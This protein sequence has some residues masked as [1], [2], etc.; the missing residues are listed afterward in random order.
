MN[1]S[2]ARPSNET[3]TGAN[4]YTV[5]PGHTLRAGG[6]L[7]REGEKAPLSDADARRLLESGAI[8]AAD[9]GTDA[10]PLEAAVNG[11]ASDLVASL[12]TMDDAQLD[13]IEQLERE[14]GDKA[15][16]TVLEGIEAARK[17]LAD[18]REAEQA[19][20]QA[21]ADNADTGTQE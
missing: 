14:R 8:A 4:A 7:Y 15:R 5:R 1:D 19:Q 6:R 9:G 11:K 16:K 17:H 2:T 13:R 12:D 20:L 18:A 21:D 10:D 3:I